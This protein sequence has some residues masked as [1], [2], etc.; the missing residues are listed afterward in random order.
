MQN[1]NT[2][3]VVD[4]QSIN[5]DF[6]VTNFKDKYNIKVASNGEM[7]LKVLDKFKIDLVLLDIQM[8][9]MDG[10]ETIKEIKKQD[11][12]K[13][14]PVI[15][16]T[17]K[18]DSDSLIKGFELGAKDYVRKPFNTKE[19][20]VR[21]NNHLETYKLIKR[22][23]LSYKNLEK[24]LDTQAN[25]VILT[26]GEELKFA[27][28]KFFEFLNFENLEKFKEKHK[29]IC[30]FFIEDENFFH[31]KKIEEGAN[32]LDE[33]SLL[34]DSQ[35]VVLIKNET[36]ELAFS[37]AINQ[38]D[39]DTMII[40]FTDISE[41]FNQ[42]M[43]L[44]KKILHDK[45]TNAYNREF[46]D[47]NYKKFISEYST[48]NSKLAIAMLDIDHFKLVNDNYGHDIGDQ[49]LIQFVDTLHK[50]S[51]KNDILVRWGGEEFIMILKIDEVSNLQKILESL[52]K[53]IESF[54]FNTVG[55]KTCSIGGTIYLENEDI[56][57]TIKRADDAVYKAKEL[58]RNKVVIF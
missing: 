17:A 20:N 40:N 9:I 35:R 47:Q 23:E 27:N 48:S 29:C 43:I 22:L 52:R 38:Y 24:L 55:H 11:R 50:N 42:K 18:T 49:V 34:E 25:I 33:I 28:R 14:L 54:N 26:N 32:W 39:I 58:G 41:T 36:K 16:L 44:E 1:K 37:V 57:K 21:V 53:S 46:F 2:I 6:I 45:L 13:D 19:L 31:L 4:D 30:E 51:R 12:F 3:L 5:I 56:L 7:A 8:P 10:Y 15:F